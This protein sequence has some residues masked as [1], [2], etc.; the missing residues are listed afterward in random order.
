MRVSVKLQDFCVIFLRFF[1]NFVDIC[2]L[3]VTCFEC[4][5]EIEL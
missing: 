4:H 5:M 1:S 3:I 2:V